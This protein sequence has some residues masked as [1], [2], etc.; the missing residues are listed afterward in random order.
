MADDF[1]MCVEELAQQNKDDTSVREN[2]SPFLHYF[3][4]D[5]PKVV[6]TGGI[7]GTLPPLSRHRPAATSATAPAAVPTPVEAFE[8]E[9][10]AAPSAAKVTSPEEVSSPIAEPTTIPT[11]QVTS[12]KEEGPT[13][14]P[15]STIHDSRSQRRVS[16]IGARRPKG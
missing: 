11:I 14:F 15:E 6:R 7:T 10:E 5:V 12:P 13:A 9:N 8:D 3:G 1:K 2:K 16:Q 4:Q